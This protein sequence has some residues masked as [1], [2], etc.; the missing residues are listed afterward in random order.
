MNIGKELISKS[1]FN[2]RE[3]HQLTQVQLANKLGISMR[4]IRRWERAK[5]LPN[6][7]STKA[8]IEQKILK[9]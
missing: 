9:V 3:Q 5:T 8:L 2:Y 7:L 1:I 4:Q 6:H